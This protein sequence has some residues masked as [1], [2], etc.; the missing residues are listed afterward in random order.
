MVCNAFVKTVFFFDDNI[1]E[2][3]PN[4]TIFLIAIP[5]KQFHF[6]G[7]T[8]ITKLI[9]SGNVS[10]MIWLDS[11]LQPISLSMFFSPSSVLIEQ[12]NGFF[13]IESILEIF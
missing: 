2:R 13:E 11:N 1:N 5:N 7:D 6:R 12:L 8:L 10:G 3:C 4:A 9:D